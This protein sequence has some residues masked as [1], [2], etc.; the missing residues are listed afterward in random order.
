MKSKKLLAALLLGIGLCFVSIL[1][2]AEI[3]KYENMD[4]IF[5]Q[6]RT[7]YM[8]ANPSSYLY[9]NFYYDPDGSYEEIF[10][11]ESLSEEFL[12]EGIKTKG[13]IFIEIIDNRD[14]LCLY[15]AKGGQGFARKL[16][17]YLRT[18]YSFVS[19]L[20]TNMN[21]DIVAGFYTTCFRTRQPKALLIAFF[22]EGRYFLW[23]GGHLGKYLPVWW[24]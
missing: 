19:P 22:Y 6:T 5:E 23:I 11:K 17:R 12:S 8:M 4:A 20:T 10:P 13:K 1:G 2:Y 16:Q 9:V 14:V 15:K 24:E 21:T 7:N 18:I 3:K